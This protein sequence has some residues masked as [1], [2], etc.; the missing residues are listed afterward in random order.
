M[1]EAL[2]GLLFVALGAGCAGSP[3][4]VPES[5]TLPRPS[6]STISSSEALVELPEIVLTADLDEQPATWAPIALIPIGSAQ[7]ELGYRLSSEGPTVGPNSFAIAP[8]GSFWIIDAAKQRVAHYSRSGQLIGTIPDSVGS[9]STDL[10]FIGQTLWVISVHHKGLVFPVLPNGR[11]SAPSVITEAGKTVYA[12]SFIPTEHGLFAEIN[13]YTDP[14]ATGPIGIYQVDLPG[15]G[16][17]SEVPGIEL[18]S[19]TAFR[20]SFSRDREF[21]AHFVRENRDTVQPFRIDVIAS[22]RFGDRSL[23]GPAVA[24]NFVVDGDDVYM[25]VMTSVTKPGS[26]GDQI[27]GRFLLRVGESPMLFERLP[28]PSLA[29]DTQVRRIALGPD[30]HLYLMQLDKDGVR[31]FRR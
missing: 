7:S 23:M 14:V 12:R 10:T 29:D 30:G 4:P 17:I 20:L 3:A 2:F 19:G 31:I 1:R 15:T 6:P 28:E 8:D 9:G 5:S 22:K 16:Y 11:R 25:H 27:G 13:G 24:T 26:G 18:E 21:G